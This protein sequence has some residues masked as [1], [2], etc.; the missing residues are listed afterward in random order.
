MAKVASATYRQVFLGNSGFLPLTY[1]L[2]KMLP[3][4]GVAF[5][6]LVILS[7]VFSRTPSPETDDF[8]DQIHR[9]VYTARQNPLASSVLSL[10]VV[11]VSILIGL[12]LSSQTIAGYVI[13]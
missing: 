11:T 12:R 6:I 5:G 9:V 1:I 3:I 4:I 8:L 2:P 10:L 13:S 7:F